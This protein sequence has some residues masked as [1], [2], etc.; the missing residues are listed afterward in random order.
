M[1]LF[2]RSRVFRLGRSSILS[3][4][5]P[6]ILLLLSIKLTRLFAFDSSSGITA[7]LLNE[8]LRLYR[9]RS[10]K[11]KVGID[12]PRLE[13]T[14]VK[15]ASLDRAVIEGGIGGTDISLI[16]IAIILSLSQRIVTLLQQDAD[17]I[18]GSQSFNMRQSD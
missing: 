10:E 6:V 18:K 4:I 8:R 5:G 11:I 12:P 13:L 1:G 9:L 17:G 15:F 3:E 16:L 7:K 2:D 14:S